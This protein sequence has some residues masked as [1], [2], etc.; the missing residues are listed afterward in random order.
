MTEVEVG[1]CVRRVRRGCHAVGCAL[2]VPGA[3]VA[4]C[5][6]TDAASHALPDAGSS[7]PV[8]VPS[9]S[10][11]ELAASAESPRGVGRG[12]RGKTFFSEIRLRRAWAA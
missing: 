11:G 2:A 7:L 12:G 6:R 9:K 4:A 10:G 3:D 1:V 5:V 8:V